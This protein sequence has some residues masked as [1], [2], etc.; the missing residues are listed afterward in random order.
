[1]KFI[2]LKILAVIVVFTVG[3]MAQQRMQPLGGQSKAQEEIADEKNGLPE[4]E[5]MSL[6]NTNIGWEGP[7]SEDYIVGPG[8]VFSV[9]IL[10][11]EQAFY[12]VPVGPDGSI[13]LPGTGKADV[14]N[15]TLNQ[16]VSYIQS[17]IK[18]QYPKAKISV[19]LSQIKRLNIPISGALE[20]P[21]VVTVFA[22]TRLSDIL[23]RHRI[24]PI[25]RLYAVQIHHNN[26]RVDT[27]NVIKNRLSGSID[28]NPM[29]LMGDRI[30]I[31]YGEID[32]DVVHVT[33]EKEFQSL[34]AVEPGTTLET[35][36]QGYITY[37]SNI[38]ISGIT[39]IR[40]GERFDFKPD[41][42]SSYRIKGGDI[43]SLYRNEP[44]SVVGF[45]HIPG[46][47]PYYPNFTVNDYI[48]LAGGISR[49]GSMKSIKILRSDGTSDSDLSSH[50]N[51]GDVI[52]V[53]RSFSDFLVGDI[54]VLSVI[55]TT[56][57]LILTWIAATK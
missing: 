48:S 43:L 53:K 17:L 12:Q 16:A 56:A 37:S 6:L 4:Y 33:G 36:I 19:S 34:I 40:N 51:P 20:A 23:M 47:Y 44:V 7:V 32:K 41:E 9:S 50:L 46:S 31:P 8:D 35:F 26:G 29:L 15:M 45:V 38:N 25:A 14:K 55:T 49:E 1:M 28:D 42:Y 10:S 54:N 27:V 13:H 52:E 18:R 5:G 39:V 3:L 21:G 11:M 2:N 57:S 22:N 30:Y 24:K